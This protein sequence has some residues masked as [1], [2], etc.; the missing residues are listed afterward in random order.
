MRFAI[1]ALLVGSSLLP[2]PAFADARSKAR[3]SFE[4]GMRLIDKKNYSQ[5]I[6]LLIKANEALPHP[7]V[8]FNIARARRGG[9]IPKRSSGSRRISRSR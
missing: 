5:G 9:F 3:R 2:A 6:E 1:V 4:E 8:Q 7:D